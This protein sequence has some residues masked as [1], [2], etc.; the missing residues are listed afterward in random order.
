MEYLYRLKQKFQKNRDKIKLKYFYYSSMITKKNKVFGIGDNKTG[1]TSLAAAME[2]LGFVVG[3][4]KEGTKLIKDWAVRD[5]QKIIKYCHTA[6]FFQDDP[7]SKPYTYVVLD[8]EFPNSKFILTV[9][10][11]AEQW[12]NSL[13]RH[14]SKKHG[15]NGQLPTKSD[16]QNSNRIHKGFMWEA[17]RLVGVTPDND[18]F[19]KDL[20]IEYYNRRNK[21]IIEYFKHRQQD[22]LILNVAEKDSLK[23]LSDFLN[24]KSDKTEFPWKNKS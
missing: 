3:I 7:F 5:F 15:Q 11:D 2:D 12:Y 14:M 6:D 19:N 21:N 9:R 16:L 18:L 10:D 24:V 22:L 1:S 20:L 17:N 23:K 13:V 8:Q 4:E